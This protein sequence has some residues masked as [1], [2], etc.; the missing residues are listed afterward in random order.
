MIRIHGP[1]PWLGFLIMIRGDSK[2][3]WDYCG[4]MALSQGFGLLFWRLSLGPGVKACVS[5][6]KVSRMVLGGL[7]NHSMGFWQGS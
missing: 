3:F 7:C 4:T 2:G 6:D 1:E 5:M